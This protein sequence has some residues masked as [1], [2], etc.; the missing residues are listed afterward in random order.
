MNGHE[1]VTT[2][3]LFDSLHLI[4][5][6][7]PKRKVDYQMQGEKLDDPPHICVV[8]ILFFKSQEPYSYVFHDITY[9]FCL[10]IYFHTWRMRTV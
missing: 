6:I 4:S 1:F 5:D 8:N 10:C 9:S 7:S 2:N 3:L